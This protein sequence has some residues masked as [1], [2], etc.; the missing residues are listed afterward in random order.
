MGQMRP[1]VK[2]VL[3]KTYLFQDLSE[4][5]MNYIASLLDKELIFR[6]DQYIIHEGDTT[7]SLFII[8]SGSVRLVRWTNEQKTEQKD[9]LSLKQGEVFGE[10]SLITGLPRTCSVIANESSTLLE[11]TEINFNMLMEKYQNLKIKLALMVE[12]R[13]KEHA[14]IFK[15]PSQMNLV[16]PETSNGPKGPRKKKKKKTKKV[17]YTYKDE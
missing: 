6:R 15:T 9:I 12:Q 17:L 1:F 14:K 2:Q 7:K 16:T 10:L 11:L 4:E 8:Q 3:S 5:Q 13:L